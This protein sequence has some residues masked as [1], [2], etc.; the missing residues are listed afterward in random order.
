M[1]DHQ[2]C[3]AYS[4]SGCGPLEGF[5]PPCWSS[6]GFPSTTELERILAG[7]QGCFHKLGVLFE[8]VLI[9]RSRLF[10]VCIRAPEFWKLPFPL[11][12]NPPRPIM[13]TLRS[14][15]FMAS[16]KEKNPEQTAVLLGLS[17][18]PQDASVNEG[19]RAPM[20]TP[21]DIP[22]APCSWLVY[23]DPKALICCQPHGTRILH[24]YMEAQNYRQ[25]YVKV[26]HITY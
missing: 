1:W 11:L 5:K 22:R 10:G 7:T 13:K 16:S 20:P 26:A 15:C 8:G 24:S 19:S 4:T 17:A 25:L 14:T 9:I 12:G 6:F 3:D 21:E 2:Q 18:K 23:I